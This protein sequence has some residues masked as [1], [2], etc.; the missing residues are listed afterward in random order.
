[1]IAGPRNA[2]KSSLFNA[3]LGRDAAIVT[4]IAGTTR[5]VLEAQVVRDGLPFRLVDTAGLTDHTADPVEAI[6]ILKARNLLA[7]ADEVLWLGPPEQA[8]AGATKIGARSDERE[9]ADAL[10]DLATSTLDPASID[11][12]WRR[13]TERARAALR[14]DGAPLLRERQRVLVAKAIAVLSQIGGGDLLLDAEHV[15]VANRSLAAIVGRD[16][17]EAM[18]DALFG[19]FCLGK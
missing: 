10:I 8:P 17:T 1:V 9:Y 5:D 2:G 16:A 3:L 19:R 13:L 11:R 7:V 12:L 14:H 4:D 18:L 6:G 15:R